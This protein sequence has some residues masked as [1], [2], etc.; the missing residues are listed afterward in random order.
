M[1]K[2]GIIK[3]TL[4]G[5][6]ITALAT[7]ASCTK[8]DTEYVDVN[9]WQT[10]ISNMR[11][12]SEDGKKAA[13][14]V[15]E[16]T[17]L[18]IYI[19]NAETE[20]KTNLSNDPNNSDMPVAFAGNHLVTKSTDTSGNL[21]SLKIYDTTTG[22]VTFETSK[23]PWL[24]DIII[25]QD[26]ARVAYYHNDNVHVHEIGTS[27][28]QQ[29]VPGA[30]NS[31]I[32]RTSHDQTIAFITSWN[33]S[34]G[35]TVSMLKTADGSVTPIINLNN[36]YVEAIAA[37]NSKAIVSYWNGTSGIK[38]IDI[39]TGA[40]QIIN[41]PANK[42]MAGV[43]NI[44]DDGS[45]LI[46]ELQNVG[47]YKDQFWAYNL[48]IDTWQFI[49]DQRIDNGPDDEEEYYFEGMTPDGNV[50]AF[51]YDHE[52]P[53]QWEFG[54]RLFNKTTQEMYNPLNGVADLGW[55]EEE[56]FTPDNK[57]LIRYD[58]T[59][60]SRDYFVLHDPATKTNTQLGETGYTNRWTGR[61]TSD[62]KHFALDA[63]EDATGYNAVI[64]E[65]LI[66]GT[67]AIIKQAG[68]HFSYVQET[69]GFVFLEGRDSLSNNLFAYDIAN[70]VLTPVTSHTD[71]RV[72]WFNIADQANDDS[73]VF[74]EERYANG[75][76]VLKELEYSTGDL[77]EVSN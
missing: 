6:L 14:A 20:T 58:L 27:T 70:D 45:T 16:Q 63:T 74:F 66:N 38:E 7:L 68:T 42:E 41:L 43:K 46:A 73:R 12:I 69:D 13:L 71:N 49:T 61:M 53:S 50:I 64:L 48:A 30:E 44:S 54:V 65:N 2:P 77:D 29:A 72:S 32:Q 24:Y 19:Y 31:N 10:P 37:D 60:D 1:K 67:N 15:Q 11:V 25:S 35:N 4:T 36:H 33:Q 17:D 76:K 59:T 57:V 47:E 55:T 23:T 18:E 5:L 8:T 22:E 40:V 75:T 39:A 21:N 51:E 34:T 56:G 62:R 26:G 28:S 9:H 52:M 3:T